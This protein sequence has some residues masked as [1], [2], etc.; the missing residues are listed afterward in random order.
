[1]EKNSQ[2]IHP[3]Q[4]IKLSFCLILFLLLWSNGKEQGT[5]REESWQNGPVK[6]QHKD[7]INTADLS[8]QVSKVL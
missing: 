7:R 3:N 2:E 8:E 6:K 4:R 1:M 5:T